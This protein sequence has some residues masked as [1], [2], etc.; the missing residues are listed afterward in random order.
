MTVKT[1]LVDE[2]TCSWSPNELRSPS[3]PKV[4]T[5]VM[6]GPES[7]VKKPVSDNTTTDPPELFTDAKPS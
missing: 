2:L 1:G 3:K 4:P 6:T 5:C 7:G